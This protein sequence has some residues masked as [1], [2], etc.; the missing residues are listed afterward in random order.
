MRPLS[1]KSEKFLLD[2]KLVSKNLEK[3]LRYK[4]TVCEIEGVSG[5]GGF[6]L[7]VL[8]TSERYTKGTGLWVSRQTLLRLLRKSCLI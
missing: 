5:F 3:T 2:R 4:N 8:R 1:V 7:S 6:Y